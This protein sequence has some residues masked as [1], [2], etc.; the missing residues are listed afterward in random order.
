MKL[1]NVIVPT[2]Q[3]HMESQLQIPNWL[4]LFMKVIVVHLKDNTET[5]NKTVWKEVEI[6]KLTAG[7]TYNNWHNAL[8]L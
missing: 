6:L 3:K 1:L 2:L 5:R 4:M 8:T 7:A